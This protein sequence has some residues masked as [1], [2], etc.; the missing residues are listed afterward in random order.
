MLKFIPLDFWCHLLC[1]SFAVLV[2]KGKS[3]LTF[4]AAELADGNRNFGLLPFSGSLPVAFVRF[5]FPS[6]LCPGRFLTLSFLC[7]GTRPS[8]GTQGVAVLPELWGCLLGEDEQRSWPQ[9]R[10]RLCRTVLHLHL[11]PHAGWAGPLTTQQILTYTYKSQRQICNI[12][13][14]GSS[15][16]F[17]VS[18][19]C[20]PYSVLAG[21]SWVCKCRSL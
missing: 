4:G 5:P 14:S 2:E 13:K 12:W 18:D 11:V 17:W 16:H 19:S 9:Q 21:D 8:G 1:C 10:Q 15:A 6:P 7:Q 20:Q 3:T